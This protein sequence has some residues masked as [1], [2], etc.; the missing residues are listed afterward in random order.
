[1]KVLKVTAITVLL[2]IGLLATAVSPVFAQVAPG[3]AKSSGERVKGYDDWHFSVNL[4]GWLTSFQGDV[5]AEGDTSNVNVDLKDVLDLLFHGKI[6]FTI[7]GRFEVSKGPWGFYT[8]LEYVRLS[9]SAEGQKNIDIPI[10]RP[11][12][13]TIQGNAKVMGV[14]SAG[15]AALTYDVYASPC[16]VANMP[17]LVAEVLGGARYQYIRTKADLELAGPLRDRSFESDDSK[18]WVDPFV[19]GRIL[20]RPGESW[21][22]S[23]E[24]DFGGF[25]VGSDFTFNIRAEAAYRINR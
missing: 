12:G 25:G 23:L 21:I 11:P 6:D 15:E 3:S 7:D 18:S 10:F 8:E 16:L 14:Y 1:M 2:C 4:A 19:G 24:T 5:T 13:F 17:E 22:T 20:W 9:D